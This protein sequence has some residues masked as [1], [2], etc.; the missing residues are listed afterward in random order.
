MSKK[1]DDVRP[2]DESDTFEIIETAIDDLDL[3]TRAFDLIS[4]V[5]QEEAEDDPSLDFEPAAPRLVL[6]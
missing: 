3:L 6:H 4:A 5:C 2:A 1:L